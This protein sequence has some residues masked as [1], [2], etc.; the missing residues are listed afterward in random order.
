MTAPGTLWHYDCPN[1]GHDGPHHLFAVNEAE[2][3]D[4]YAEFSVNPAD[5]DRRALGDGEQG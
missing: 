1:C 5:Y 3:G 2:C 4:C